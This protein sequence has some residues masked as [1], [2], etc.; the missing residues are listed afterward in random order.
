[1][2]RKEYHKKYY[3]NKKKNVLQARKNRYAKDPLY[4]ARISQAAKLRSKLITL[5]RHLS[6]TDTVVLGKGASG[7]TYLM[8]LKDFRNFVQRG[9]DTLSQ[10][11]REGII[12]KPI[13]THPTSTRLMYSY[14]QA[15]Y[16]EKIL[17]AIDSY[18]IEMSYRQLSKFLKGVWKLPFS[19]KTYMIEL[20]RVTGG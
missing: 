9:E 19:E 16:M 10:W 20:N 6:N 13:Y 17:A 12:P 4:R 15:K 8:T 3:Q 5:R 11:E 14:S 7:K 2:K 1:M 18:R